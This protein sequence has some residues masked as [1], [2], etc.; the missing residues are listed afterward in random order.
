MVFRMPPLQTT[1]GIIGVMPLALSSGVYT[2]NYAGIV[3]REINQPQLKKLL[4][5]S[6]NPRASWVGAPLIDHT[7][8]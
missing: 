3:G 7:G 4:A 6:R 2:H 1:K 5:T 8:T